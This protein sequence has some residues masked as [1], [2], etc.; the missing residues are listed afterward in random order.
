MLSVQ[1]NATKKN[2]KAINSFFAFKT[3]L[4]NLLKQLGIG[5]F[6][7]RIFAEF[8]GEI[9]DSFEQLKPRYRCLADEI[10]RK[11]DKNTIDDG[12]WANNSKKYVNGS[13]YPTMISVF[14]ITSCEAL[15]P[16]TKLRFEEILKK[17]NLNESQIR[18]LLENEKFWKPDIDYWEQLQKNKDN[19]KY[20]KNTFNRTILKKNDVKSSINNRRSKQR[21]IAPRVVSKG[22][23]R[24]QNIDPGIQSE[25]QGIS[26][27]NIFFEHPAKILRN[28]ILGSITDF[29][30]SKYIEERKFIMSSSYSENS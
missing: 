11:D 24:K 6:A 2:T 13:Q 26:D 22:E 19:V 30:F 28:E 14:G 3:I 25:P 27:T 7:A 12:S 20:K 5:E 15:S 16:D 29:G 1:K 21:R 18:K 23:E 4:L 10:N 17:H 9:W 8:A